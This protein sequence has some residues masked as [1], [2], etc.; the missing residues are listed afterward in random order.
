MEILL[1]SM[2]SLVPTKSMTQINEG[3][4]IVDVFHYAS[5][6]AYAFLKSTVL[7]KQICFVFIKQMSNKETQW[8]TGN[9]VFV[10]N[11]GRSVFVCFWTEM[12]I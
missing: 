4:D 2:C 12:V 8:A 10:G 3:V 1:R 9:S 11:V 6:Q 5:W 7:Y